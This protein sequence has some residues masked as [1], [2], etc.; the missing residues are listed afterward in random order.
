[1]PRAHRVTPRSTSVPPRGPL[2]A[3]GEGEA[4]ARE[5]S[6]GGWAAPGGPA[7][8]SQ[9]GGGGGGGGGTPSPAPAGGGASS[10]EVSAGDPGHRRTP[11]G[12][13][14]RICVVHPAMF[15]AHPWRYLLLVLLFVGGVAG[16]LIGVIRREQF[17]W[18]LYVGA[19][20]TVAA[21]I[22]WFWWWFFGT[23]CIKLEITS[24]RSIRQEGFIRRSTTEVLHDH[25]RSV[26]I[27]QSFADRVLNVG[28]I[29]IDSA[30]QDGVEI[31]INDIPR[32]YDVKAIIDRY[33]RM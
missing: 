7:C 1:M 31:E 15:R 14:E 22:W 17:G 32:P 33:R 3:A 11:P 20:A 28:Y 24:K 13:E 18:L 29:G 12:P 19:P 4:V 8:W 2:D 30:G 10:G 27:T 21:V 5:P 16:L 23:I 25:V 26:D 9:A 6:L